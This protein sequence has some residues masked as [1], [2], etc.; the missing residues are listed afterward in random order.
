[1]KSP[2]SLET[3]MRAGLTWVLVLVMLLV[4]CLG[5]AKPARAEGSLVTEVGMGYKIEATTSTVLLPDCHRVTGIEFQPE[6]REGDESWGRV[7]ASCGGD[8]PV[9]IGWPL[10]Y[11]WESKTGALRWRA[12]WFHYSHWFDGHSDRET[13][14]DAAAVSV[15]IVWGKRK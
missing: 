8:N 9:F 4:L 3:K 11:E 1:M 2:K 10:A 15:T 5:F 12:G 6:Q 7:S 13:H 14:F